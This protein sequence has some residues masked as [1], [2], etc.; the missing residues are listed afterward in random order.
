[1][2]KLLVGFVAAFTVSL[3]AVAGNAAAYTA[4]NLAVAFLDDD[5]STEY[6]IEIGDLT[7][8][9][10][11]ASNVELAAAGSFNLDYDRVGMFGYTVET[12]IPGVTVQERWF[13]LTTDVEATANSNLATS[14]V[15]AAGTTTLGEHSMSIDASYNTGMNS[16]GKA[17]GTYSGYNNV[18]FS[19]GEAVL[20]EDSVDMYLYYF[21]AFSNLVLDGENNYQA[22]ISFNGDGSI[23]L[24]QTSTVPVPGAVVLLGTGLVG[25][26][27]L[28]RKMS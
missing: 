14:F 9:D 4:G 15:G 11:S 17:D 27:G 25:L 8:M 10:L 21:D 12:P 3:F 16:G 6:V 7:S 18:Y 5:T 22:V 20:S 13:G 19:Y 26:V 1:M 2:K 24:N 28:R 23:V